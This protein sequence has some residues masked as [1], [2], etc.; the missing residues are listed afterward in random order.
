MAGVADDL[1][2]ALRGAG[3]AARAPARARGGPGVP[4][5]RGGCVAGVPVALRAS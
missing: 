4:G 2:D 3:R 5:R 1:P